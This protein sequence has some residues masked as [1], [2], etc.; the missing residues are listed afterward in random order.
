[1]RMLALEVAHLRVILPLSD[2][3]PRFIDWGPRANDDDGHGERDD[4]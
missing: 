3:A 4:D 1:M 2:F